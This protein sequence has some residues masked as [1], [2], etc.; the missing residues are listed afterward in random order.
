M[1]GE[2]ERN[3]GVHAAV[4]MRQGSLYWS[5]GLPCSGVT[6]LRGGLRVLNSCVYTVALHPCEKTGIR[7][8]HGMKKWCRN[9]KGGLSVRHLPCA[10]A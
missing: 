6:I 4:Q 8:R 9:G 10:A 7:V 5:P 1:E 3:G 2:I